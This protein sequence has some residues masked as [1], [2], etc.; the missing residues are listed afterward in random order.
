MRAHK[1][2]VWQGHQVGPLTRDGGVP[3]CLQL[4]TQHQELA[5]WARA[6]WRWGPT[7]YYP[8]KA[9]GTGVAWAAPIL[10]VWGTMLVLGG[11][12]PELWE[13]PRGCSPTKAAVSG[14]PH[15]KQALTKRC[16]CR[17]LHDDNM[18]EEGSISV[19]LWFS[20]Y[21]EEAVWM[22]DDFSILYGL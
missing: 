18:E 9:C 10:W 8:E 3:G 2:L 12:R 15:V 16:S 4:P 22:D 14:R 21:L 11:G 5:A 19:Y 1:R 20:A 7:G 13:L 17:C 6:G